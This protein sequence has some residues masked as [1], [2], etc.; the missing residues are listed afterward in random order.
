MLPD[1]PL[2]SLNLR[3]RSIVL[4]AFV[5]FLHHARVFL[6]VT[7]LL[8]TLASACS[9]AFQST[10]KSMMDDIS[11]SGDSLTAT[12]PCSIASRCCPQYDKIHPM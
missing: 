1:S 5:P 7:V 12:R 8:Q 11:D 10:R 3:R 9:P 2:L 4:L 6:G